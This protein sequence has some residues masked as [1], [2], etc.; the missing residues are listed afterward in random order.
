MRGCG[1]LGFQPQLTKESWLIIM[2][3][4][5]IRYAD[6]LLPLA[7]GLTIAS[8]LLA[9]RKPKQSPWMLTLSVLMLLIISSSPLAALFSKSLEAPYD[10][11]TFADRGEAIV[12]LSGA[13]SASDPYGPHVALGVDSYNRA[14]S[15]AQLYRSQ[16][17]RLVIVSGSQCAA[18]IARLLESEGVATEFILQ[19]GRANNTHENAEYSATIVR[20]K[21]IH[22]VVLVTDAKSMLRA[23]MC[24]RKEGISVVPYPVGLGRW[25]FD[26]SELIPNWEAIRSNS[27]TLHELSGLLWYRWH[28]WI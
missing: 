9:W 24:F 28:G 2:A 3:V 4:M 8:L 23:E 7:L 15:A 13:C 21:G 1:I 22:T 12:V 19:E 25:K 26:F 20:S 5:E 14:L 17:P 16:R 10:G 6:P 11:R 27:D 18:P